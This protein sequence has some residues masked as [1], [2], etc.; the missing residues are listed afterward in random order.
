MQNFELSVE[1]NR[2]P[3]FYVFKNRNLKYQK[4]LYAVH[5][6]PSISA[7]LNKRKISKNF[8]RSP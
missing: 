6:K 7:P 5:N 2:I 1:E 8:V 4:I 3:H